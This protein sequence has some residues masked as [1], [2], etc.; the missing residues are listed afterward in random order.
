MKQKSNVFA[1]K[2]NVRIKLNL[3]LNNFL[4]TKVFKKLKITN[5]II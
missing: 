5:E 2:K 1:A 4:K 3:I